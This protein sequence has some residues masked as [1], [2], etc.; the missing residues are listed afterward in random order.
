MYCQN[1]NLFQWTGFFGWT[2]N[3]YACDNITNYEKCENIGPFTNH[4]INFCTV[5]IFYSYVI[6]KI[7]LMRA[8]QPFKDK[9]DEAFKSISLTMLLLTGVY[10]AF[11][12]PIAILETCSPGSD[13]L[14]TT[15]ERAIIA[16]W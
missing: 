1:N 5:I 11:L 16:N 3:A 13:L 10:L 6:I 8:R 2:G 15:L 9:N 14:N 4:I 12:F 7:I